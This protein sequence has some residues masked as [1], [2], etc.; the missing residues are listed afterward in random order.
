MTGQLRLYPTR[1][2]PN[3]Q[4]A[5]RRAAALFPRSKGFQSAYLKGWRARV[6]KAGLDACPY[7]RHLYNADGT[8]TW[9]WAWRSAWMMGYLEGG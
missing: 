1:R 5:Q 7:N 3:V 8:G 9:A 6:A 2:Q 4:R